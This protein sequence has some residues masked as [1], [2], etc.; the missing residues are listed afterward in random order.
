MLCL[1]F[2]AYFDFLAEIGG[3][4]AWVVVVVAAAPGSV[5]QRLLS[6]LSSMQLLPCDVVLNHACCDF[7]HLFYA[8]D[9]LPPGHIID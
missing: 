5:E 9:C 4:V 7:A 8:L 6:A 3:A 2:L 1:A